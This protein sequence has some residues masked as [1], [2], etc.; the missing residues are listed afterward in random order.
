MS[1]VK[2]IHYSSYSDELLPEDRNY[3]AD[4]DDISRIITYDLEGYRSKKIIENNNKIS[5]EL[6]INKVNT[7]TVHDKYELEGNPV[8]IWEPAN[9]T[10]VKHEYN[11]LLSRTNNFVSE[12]TL[13]DYREFCY[14]QDCIHYRY[15]YFAMKRLFPHYWNAI[16][17]GAQNKEFL[18][19]TEENY[20]SA[21]KEF[22]YTEYGIYLIEKKN[23]VNKILGWSIK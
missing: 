17:N 12:K 13:E 2:Q 20:S 6:G 21:M 3:W 9:D 7:I 23:F 11:L 10:L 22:S 8:V 15:T 16:F 1:K 14:I 18:Y 4:I 5:Y 19:S